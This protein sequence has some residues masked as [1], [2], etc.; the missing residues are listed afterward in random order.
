MTP[1]FS[2][3]VVVV[4]SMVTVCAE[5]SEGELT[6]ARPSALV[7][8]VAWQEDSASSETLDPD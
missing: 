2:E 3:V 8:A 5:P 7:K 4:P 1:R 6:S